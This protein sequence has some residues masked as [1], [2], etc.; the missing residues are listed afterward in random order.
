MAEET[1]DKKEEHQNGIINLV[2]IAFMDGLRTGFSIAKEGIN[3]TFNSISSEETVGKV[4]D[5]YIDYWLKGAEKAKE[6]TKE[7]DEKH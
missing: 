5:N 3:Q 7:T 6:E 2:K 4:A 1:K